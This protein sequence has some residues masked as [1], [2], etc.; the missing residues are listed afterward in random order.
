MRRFHHIRLLMRPLPTLLL[1]L[2]L[3]GWCMAAPPGPGAMSDSAPRDPGWERLKREWADFLDALGAYT[4]DKQR[5]ALEE[6]QRLLQALD[7]QIAAL[8]SALEAQWSKHADAGRRRTEQALREL[9]R[10]RQALTR[11][12]ERMQ[13]ASGA[14]W[15][16]AKRRFDQAYRAAEKRLDELLG[17]HERPTRPRRAPASPPPT[18]QI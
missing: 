3:P 17:Q 16:E 12:Y 15:E 4:A 10:E 11:W 9:Q 6:T 13:R 8:Q 2:I 14:Q 5:Q 18:T 7:Q 1:L